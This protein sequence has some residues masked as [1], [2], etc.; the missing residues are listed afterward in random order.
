[1][2]KVFYRD[3]PC[4]VDRLANIVGRQHVTSDEEQIRAAGFTKVARPEVLASPANLEEIRGTIILAEELGTTIVPVGGGTQIRQVLD[5]GTGGIGLCLKRCDTVLEMLPDNLSITVEAGVTNEQVQLLAAPHNLCL[6]IAA[7]C[8]D[9]TV[10][11]EIV[12]N[13]SGWKRYSQGS[14]RDYV[15]GLTFISPTGS[16]VSTGGKT[17]KNV[18]GYDLTKL[19]SGSWGTMGVLHSATLRLTPRPIRDLVL[20][21][22]CGS[23]EQALQEGLSL[24]D[25]GGSLA[26]CNLVS[27]PAA[28]QSIGPTL[29]SAIEGSDAFVERQLSRIKTL[30]GWSAIEA[31]GELGHATSSYRR[32]RSLIKRGYYHTVIIDKRALQRSGSLL[33]FLHEWQC[34][35]DFD[36]TA[37]V[38]EFCI[39]EQGR[40]LDDHQRHGWLEVYRELREHIIFHSLSTTSPQPL[41]NRLLP[42]VDPQGTMF[43][44][45]IYTRSSRRV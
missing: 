40:L 16:L 19:I 17:V 26:S 14:I 1:M 5:K 8:A 18:S 11:G 45:N 20:E 7:D 15:L 27:C 21:R 9:S 41:L 35:F 12:A 30:Q 42:V 39:P 25:G 44:N 3:M 34:S 29:Y 32:A 13:F 36:L 6:P 23:V 22:Q 31:V 28:E 10:G 4:D 43:R 37:G 2:N 33:R 38:V 24:L